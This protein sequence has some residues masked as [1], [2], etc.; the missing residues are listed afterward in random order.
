M[1]ELNTMYRRRVCLTSEMC[2][3][4]VDCKPT[5][6]LTLL[7]WGGGMAVMWVMAKE[8][9][10]V[11]PEIHI[12]GRM[13]WLPGICFFQEVGLPESTTQWTLTFTAENYYLYL[14]GGADLRIDI[15]AFM[16][17]FQMSS[18]TNKRTKRMCYLLSS[19]ILEEIQPNH[20]GAL[21]KVYIH[22]HY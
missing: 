16:F 18:T 20:K 19:K 6:A 17:I 22:F 5:E 2:Q 12:R 4:V 10:W 9:C 14:R 11:Q 21:L 3:M 15:K 13:N 7:Y 8:P 1:V